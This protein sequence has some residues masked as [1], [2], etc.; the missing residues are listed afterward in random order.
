MELDTRM[1]TE[2][3]CFSAWLTCWLL[4]DDG[5]RE[6]N[7]DELMD[8]YMKFGSYMSDGLHFRLLNHV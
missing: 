8:N 7:R 2:T 5:G 3:G 6:E 4:V 1:E